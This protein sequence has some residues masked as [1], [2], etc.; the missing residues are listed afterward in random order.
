MH[1]AADPRRR[2]LVIGGVHGNEPVTPPAVRGLLD[3]EIAG[4]VEVWLV[5]ESNPDGSAAGIRCNANGVDLNR[6]FAWEWRAEDGGPAPMSE[7]ETLTLA[8]L[9][10]GLRPDVVIWVHQPLGYVSAVGETTAALEEAWASASGLPVRADVSQHGGGESWS[11]FTVGV[12]AMLIEID[13]WDAT[14]DIVAAQVA[15]F[16]AM[17]TALG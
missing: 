1:A 6:N 5:P 7:P 12:P 10:E 14:P 2:V 8:R 9:V 3:A 13:G 11:A 4:D 16:E 17:L 15:G